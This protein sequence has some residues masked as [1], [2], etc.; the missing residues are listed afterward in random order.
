M[1]PRQEFDLPIL[2]LDLVANSGRVSLAIIDPCPVNSMLRLPPL[3][4]QAVRCV[5]VW[6]GGVGVGGGVGGGGV[7][8][9]WSVQGGLRVLLGRVWRLTGR[10]RACW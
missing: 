8:V 1:Y 3:Y 2:S 4:Q 7:V 5:C 6:G 9:V 10:A